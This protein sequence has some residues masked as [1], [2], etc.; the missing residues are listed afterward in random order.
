M[1]RDLNVD[2]RRVSVT[3]PTAARYAEA[4][5]FFMQFCVIMDIVIGTSP[6]DALLDESL[7]DFV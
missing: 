6:S 2:L 3:R 1:P 4:F 5:S 7:T